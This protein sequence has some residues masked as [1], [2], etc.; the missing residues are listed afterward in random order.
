MDTYKGDART[1]NYLLMIY[2]SFKGTF[3]KFFDSL[4][5]DIY[6]TNMCHI[7]TGK[8]N[9]KI[10]ELQKILKNIKLESKDYSDILKNTK[11][12]DFV[13]LDP[14]YIEDKKYSFEYNKNQVF[15]PVELQMELE[16]LDKKRVKW[17]MTQI[18]TQQ[19][20]E[21]FKKYTIYSYINNSNF[22]KTSTKKKE[23]I[24]TNY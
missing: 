18:D 20:R 19:V 15:D 5:G 8:Y 21:L 9:L 11:S 7:F 22:N 6:T 14:P 10:Q 1:V 24:I 3:L 13:F 2:C 12:G 23:V 17:M 16:K 4:Y